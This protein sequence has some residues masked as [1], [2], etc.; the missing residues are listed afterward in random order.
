MPHAKTQSA[1]LDA[2]Q[3]QTRAKFVGEKRQLVRPNTARDSQEE[4]SGVERHRMRMLGDACAHGAVP[5][6]RRDGAARTCEPVLSRAQ[7]DG[8]Q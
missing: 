1:R 3:L 8:V 5:Q 2:M 7:E 4:R 6:L